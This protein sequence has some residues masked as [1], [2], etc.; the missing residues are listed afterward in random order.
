MKK[1]K[2]DP[3]LLSFINYERYKYF[4]RKVDLGDYKKFLKRIGNPEKELSPS[5]IVAGTNGKGSTAAIISSILSNAG[6]K[7]GLFTSPHLLSY[8]ERI[9]INGK[10]IPRND[11]LRCINR[12]RPFLDNPYQKTHRTFFEVLTTVSFLY[13]Q[14]KKTDLNIFEVGLGGRLD[15]T[16]VVDSII[17]IITPIGFDHTHTLGHTLSKIAYEK[18]GI[19]KKGGL[20]VSA[21]QHKNALEIIK[22]VT[23]EKQ[24]R[25]YLT[26]KDI[27]ISP[28]RIDEN[29]IEFLYQQNHYHLP[30]MGNFQLE[31]LSTALLTI[32]KLKVKNIE[33]SKKNL[34]DGIRRCKWYGRLQIIRKSPYIILDGAH[35]LSAMRVML[36][37]LKKIFPSKRLLVIFSCL[38][39][40]D[41]KGMASILEKVADKIIITKI[42]SERATPIP[43]LLKVFNRHIYAPKNTDNAIALGLKLAKKKDI[44]LITGSI[45]LIA[46]AYSVL[47]KKIDF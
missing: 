5:I 36:H 44:I 27:N 19:I 24:A 13:F 34:A 8:R 21:K 37:S 25:L 6:Y 38:V 12:L 2:L 1:E 35:N 29:G 23:R 43:E 4:P 30:L 32:E 14:T 9:K 33:V 20:V 40:K 10:N 11:F 47:K 31:N 22:K 28:I 26:D 46:E 3:Y 16:N 39:S 15:A 41:R 7:V 45:Y 42:D 17:S 18:C